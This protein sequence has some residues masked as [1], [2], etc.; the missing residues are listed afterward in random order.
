M[1]VYLLIFIKKCKNPFLEEKNFGRKF[2]ILAHATWL[3]LMPA[4]F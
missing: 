1:L 2:E 4:L 3:N